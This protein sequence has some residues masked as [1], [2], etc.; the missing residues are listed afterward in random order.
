MEIPAPLA[1]QTTTLRIGRGSLS[2][3]RLQ[4]LPPRDVC[5]ECG[6]EAK[7]LYTFSGRG[8]VVLIHNHLRSARWFRQ[9]RSIHRCTRET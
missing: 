4:N 1:T 2:A 5:P 3:L 6:G 9:Q 8:E 7:T